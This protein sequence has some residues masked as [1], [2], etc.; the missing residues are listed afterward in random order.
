MTAPCAR[1]L[2]ATQHTEF[3]VGAERVAFGIASRWGLPLLAVQPLVTNAEYE[4]IAP[5]L[6]ERTD[7]DAHDRLMR[8]QAEADAAG[9][10]LD[11][12]VRRGDEAWREIVAEAALR[13][14]DLVIVRRRGREGFLANLLVGD[15]VGKVATRSPCSALLV[16]RA[17]GLWTRGVLAAVDDVD[18]AGDVASAA[19]RFAAHAGLPLAIAGVPSKHGDAAAAV[20]RALAVA[21]GA[22]IRAQASAPAIARPDEIGHVAAALGADLVVIGRRG[23]PR[24]SEWFAPSGAAERIIGGAGC[25]VL[26]V[27]H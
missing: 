6:A 18:T 15:M 21:S 24:A 4:S 1:P 22:G 17:A 2:L 13:Q 12:R 11:A 25:P 23:H 5:G 8:L 19:A 10:R 3:D 9:I 14:A 26:V 27:G 20:D 7:D 16:P